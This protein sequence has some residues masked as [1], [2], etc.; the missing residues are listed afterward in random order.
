MILIIAQMM[1]H[2]QFLLQHQVLYQQKRSLIV[3]T[4]LF[5]IGEKERSLFLQIQ[6][7]I[8][9]KQ[10]SHAETRISPLLINIIDYSTEK[11]FTKRHNYKERVF[12]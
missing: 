10:P 1:I 9:K 2:H 3:A 4:E 7:I 12:V 6:E 5:I 8:L 11:K